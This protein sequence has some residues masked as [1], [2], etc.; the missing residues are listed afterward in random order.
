MGRVKAAWAATPDVADAADAEAPTVK[1]A[2]GAR[3]IL[4]DAWHP[5]LAGGT[6]LTTDP[7]IAAAVAVDHRV[8]LAGGLS[9]TSVAEAIA[10]VR[11]WA[12]DASSALESCP[13]VK[14]PGLVAAYITAAHTEPA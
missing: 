9:A 12:V 1:P 7:A 3:A 13:G 6:G 2:A 10:E 4:L 8:V 14:D 11:P 5:T